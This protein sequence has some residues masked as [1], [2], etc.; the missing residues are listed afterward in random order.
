MHEARTHEAED[1]HEA[2]EAEEANEAEE[3]EEV[4]EQHENSDATASAP[5]SCV[6]TYF[7]CCD[8]A[9]G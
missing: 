3:I 4:H 2:S 5:L 6:L 7:S 1:S 9:N 8:A